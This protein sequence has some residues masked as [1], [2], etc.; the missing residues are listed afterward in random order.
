MVSVTTTQTHNA[1]AGTFAQAH[2][3]IQN[4]NECLAHHQGAV[5]VGVEVLDNE[6]T[7]P[8]EVD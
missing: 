4:A 2:G 5:F 3:A 6:G 1:H 7:Q 8:L